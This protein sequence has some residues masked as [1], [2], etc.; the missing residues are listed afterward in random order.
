MDG[1]EGWRE[2]IGMGKLSSLMG[3]ELNW[4]KLNFAPFL[5]AL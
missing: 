2:G 1:R 5:A 4:G 3:F